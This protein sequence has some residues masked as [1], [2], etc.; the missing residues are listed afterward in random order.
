[1]A[2]HSSQ[3]IGGVWFLWCMDLMGLFWYHYSFLFLALSAVSFFPLT[4]F[5]FL[6]LYSR[7][8]RRNKHHLHWNRSRETAWDHYYHY[9]H[10]HLGFSDGSERVHAKLWAIIRMV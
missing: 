6:F 10:Q 4:F 8:F 9:I 1:M 7:L 2:W 3:S 5:I